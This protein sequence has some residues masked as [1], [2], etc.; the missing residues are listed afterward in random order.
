MRWLCIHMGVFMKYVLTIMFSVR[1]DSINV[2][3]TVLND[4]N[5]P[6]ST[7]QLVTNGISKQHREHYIMYILIVTEF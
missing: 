4:K 1:N 2:H 3:M 7:L 6:T 5:A